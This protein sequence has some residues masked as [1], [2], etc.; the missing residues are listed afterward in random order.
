MKSEGV[1]LQ[2]ES[3]AAH[4]LSE[5]PRSCFIYITLEPDNV[6]R[7]AKEFSSASQF[8][9]MDIMVWMLLFGDG[10]IIFMIILLLKYQF[11]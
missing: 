6:K 4:F 10:L 7:L 3:F 1:G 11:A 5:I 9:P 2:H 8:T